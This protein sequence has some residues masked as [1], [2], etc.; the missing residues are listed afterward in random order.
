[1]ST[2]LTFDFNPEKNAILKRDR[3]VSFEEV[4]ATI[5][6]GKILDIVAHPNIARYP[7]QRIYYIVMRNYVYLVPFVR[8]G[9]KIFLKTVIPS[10]KLTKHYLKR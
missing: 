4:I 3:G 6:A 10:R 5:E 1:M 7:R 8:T 9:S 2:S